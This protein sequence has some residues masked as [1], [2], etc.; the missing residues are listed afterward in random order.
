MS[1]RQ[2]SIRRRCLPP[3]GPMPPQRF[4][5]PR[6]DDDRGRP[7]RAFAPRADRGGEEP[8]ARPQPEVAREPEPEN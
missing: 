1:H 4:A 5:P 2:R 3:L 6:W 7:P 8:P